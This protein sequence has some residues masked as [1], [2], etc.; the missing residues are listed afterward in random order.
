MNTRTKGNIGEDLATKYLKKHGYKIIERNYS[1]QF[2][3]IDIIAKQ[4][5]YYVF[6]EVKSRNSADFGLP[7]FAVNTRKQQ[8][9]I[10]CAKWWLSRNELMG[11]AV[12]F[13]VVEIVGDDVNV[14][15]NAFSAD[16]VHLNKK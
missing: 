4:K 13:D 9:I 11:S 2:G 1:C 7:R 10:T 15:T 16:Y 3:E 12:R 5:K 6:V 14:I 8:T